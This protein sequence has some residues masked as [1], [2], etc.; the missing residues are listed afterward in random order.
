MI[1]AHVQRDSRAIYL[2]ESG[3]SYFDA[4]QPSEKTKKIFGDIGLRVSGTITRQCGMKFKFSWEFKRGPDAD[5]RD[6]KTK[7]LCGIYKHFF[8][9]VRKSEFRVVLWSHFC[10]IISTS[11]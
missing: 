7:N 6:K 8:S 3:D 5:I 2:Y 11:Y 1:L 9:G 4:N 10:V